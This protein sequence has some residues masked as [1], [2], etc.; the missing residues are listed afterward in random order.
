MQPSHVDG[1]GHGRDGYA[2]GPDE[3]WDD[4][5]QEH[6]PQRPTRGD[7]RDLPGGSDARRED[8]CRHP[9]G[10]DR[11]PGQLADKTCLSQRPVREVEQEDPDGSAGRRGA[12]DRPDHDGRWRPH[13]GD[14]D[15]LGARRFRA[16][17]RHGHEDGD[18]GGHD[19]RSGHAPRAPELH[20]DGDEDRQPDADR[21]VPSK[22]HSGRQSGQVHDR[23]LSARC[24]RAGP[25]PAPCAGLRGLRWPGVRECT[26]CSP[27]RRWT[28]MS[29]H[30]A[31][32]VGESGR[33]PARQCGPVS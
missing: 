18:Q 10:R 29:A 30:V 7:D 14:C 3:P 23:M 8:G 22:Q 21:K 32:A 25:Y 2:W 24:L 27:G 9:R 4:D 17:A 6:G 13:G 31:P 5:H 19:R 26:G 15:P 33:S 16:E 20:A 28:A 1:Q 11:V 12:R